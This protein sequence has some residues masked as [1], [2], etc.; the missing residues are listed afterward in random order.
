MLAYRVSAMHS[1]PQLS[2][3]P[4]ATDIP[5]AGCSEGFGLPE[6]ISGE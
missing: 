6:Q 4:D 2:T 1:L 5:S 3:S